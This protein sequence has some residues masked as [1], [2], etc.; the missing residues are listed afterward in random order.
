[1][2]EDTTIASIITPLYESSVGVIRI[3]GKNA[4]PIIKKIF[5]PVNEERFK[6][7]K[8]FSVYLGNI[9]NEQGEPL[10]QVLLLLMKGPH[11]YTTEDVVEIHTHGNPYLLK[12]I[13]K[14]LIK[15]GAV[16]SEAG[17]F[18]KRAFLGGRLDL[19]QSEAV[20]DIIRSR[21]KGA[22]KASLSQLEGRLGK[23]IQ[24]LS[25]E[26]L[27]ILA[28]MEASIDF[29]EDEIEGS[30]EKESIKITIASIILSLE[31]MLQT[32][33]EGRLL[34]EGIMTILT[35]PPNVGKSTLLNQLLGEERA[36]ITEIPGTTRDSIEAPINIGDLSLNLVDT[37][38]LRETEDIIEKIGI[39][40]THE[41]LNRGDLI[42]LLLDAADPGEEELITLVKNMDKPYF[43]LYNKADKLD[44]IPDI[45]DEHTLYISG[46]EGLGIDDLK[47]KIKVTFLKKE[48]EDIYIHSLR[49]YEA[50]ERGREALVSFL[51][52][53]ETTPY[54]LLSIDLK[55]AYEALGLVTGTSLSE[56]LLDTIFSQFCIGK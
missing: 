34:K 5:H 22:V 21:S 41:Y 45:E 27:Q 18:T 52:N 48:P 38:G 11:S 46:K 31:E 33:E 15:L 49:Y 30:M 28:Y 4:L 24:E 29:P 37:A 26:I 19:S 25:A 9:T 16:Q 1:M 10:D 54:D 17:E 39:E 53:F 50:L 51:N 40:K 43:I 32:Y 13:L 44:K 56:E 8:S 42:L 55:E 6:E 2:L 14:T 7:E 23:K 35:G 3:S 47:E 36:I 20:M 12:T